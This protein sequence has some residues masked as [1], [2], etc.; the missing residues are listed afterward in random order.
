VVAGSLLP[1]LAQRDPRLLPNKDEDEDAQLSRLRNT[2][3]EW[4]TE[5]A[6]RGKPLRLPMMPFLLR[7]IWI[8]ALLLF[9]LLTF[10]TFFV[11]TVPQVRRSTQTVFFF[12]QYNPGNYN[13][14]VN[15]DMLGSSLL[16][17]VCYHHGG[18]YLVSLL[19]FTPAHRLFLSFSKSWMKIPTA[20]D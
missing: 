4:R 13:D 5:T 20:N 6:R 14:W 10:S 1:H 2:I 8:G 18:R 7:D 3:R 15:W 17:A 11:S 9:T 12:A 19:C 16:G